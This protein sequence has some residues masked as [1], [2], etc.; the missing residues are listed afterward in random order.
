MAIFANAA[1]NGSQPVSQTY[2]QAAE[3]INM[4]CGPNF[5]DSNVQ[6]TSAA[7]STPLPA[8]APS[9]ALLTLLFYLL[10]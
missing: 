3:Q 8:L 5:T 6:V 2:Q 9:A 1:S 7:A 10:F 4:G